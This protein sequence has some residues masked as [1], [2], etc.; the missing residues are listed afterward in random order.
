MIDT[1]LLPSLSP[2]CGLHIGLHELKALITSG[3]SPLEQRHVPLLHLGGASLGHWSTLLYLGV[4]S[5]GTKV[6]LPCLNFRAPHRTG[7]DVFCNWSK[8]SIS[9]HQALSPSPLRRCSL[10]SR[11]QP[12]D[13][14][15]RSP[16]PCWVTTTGYQE[17]PVICCNCSLNSS[18]M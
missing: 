14:F 1:H 8:P 10:E 9:L 4:G 2:V 16:F 12:N 18:K 17:V 6:P 15:P 5:Y 3:S 7:W 11:F 13:K